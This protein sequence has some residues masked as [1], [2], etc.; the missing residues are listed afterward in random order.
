LN[1]NFEILGHVGNFAVRIILLKTLPGTEKNVYNEYS[2]FLDINLEKKTIISWLGYKILGEYDLCFIIERENYRHDL[3]YSGTIEGITYS[4]ELLCHHWGN[5]DIRFINEALSP[6][7]MSLCILKLDPK[8]LK[9]SNL[10]LYKDIINIGDNVINTYIL[11]NLGWGEFVLLYLSDSFDDIYDNTI[12]KI[13]KIINYKLIKSLTMIGIK[14]KFIFPE[15]NCK[16]LKGEIS[17]ETKFYPTIKVSC[18]PNEVDYLCRDLMTFLDIRHEKVTVTYGIYDF[19]INIK[20][21]NWGKI[22]E[23]LVKFRDKNK[24]YINKTNLDVKGITTIQSNPELRKWIYIYSGIK[25]IKNKIDNIQ[26]IEDQIKE[27]VI[28][29]IYTFNQYLQ[30]ELLYDSIEDMINY[31]K[32]MAKLLEIIEYSEKYYNLTEKIEYLEKMPEIIKDGCNQRLGAF[33][34]Q[35]GTEDFS[36]FKGGKHLL[37]KAIKVFC[38]EIILGVGVSDWTGFIN[39]GRQNYYFQQK[40]ILGIPV[41][42]AFEVDKYFGLFHEIGHLVR[43]HLPLPLEKVVD[44][45]SRILGE[46]FCDLFAFQCGFLGDYHLYKESL[47]TFL[48]DLFKTQH[49]I[50]QYFFRFLSVY[51]YNKIIINEADYDSERISDEFSI[52]T[53]EIIDRLSK[54]QDN[55]E[56]I[57]ERL[58]KNKLTL[59]ESAYNLVIYFQEEYQNNIDWVDFVNYRQEQLNS[60]KV[61]DQFQAIFAGNVVNNLE[62]PHLIVLKF[63]KKKYQIDSNIEIPFSANIAAIQSFLNLYYRDSKDGDFNRSVGIV[64]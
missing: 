36:P 46:G 37:L 5:S 7:L 61:E 52:F 34:L 15:V 58:L 43:L 38:E 24:G 47:I 27:A 60:P 59:I 40:N 2:K 25:L 19:L 55:I 20:D 45:K 23:G 4:T 3:L 39:I 16:E 10:N 32:E 31:V 6:P 22:I 48:A 62:H 35:E 11:G 41:N 29:T 56:K 50:E 30:N 18:R 17:S 57:K 49:E 64:S 42:I 28:S 13:K 9:D 21:G 63:L 26:N 12:H 1:T 53:D 14:D 51:I 54:G 8:S 33:L 44:E